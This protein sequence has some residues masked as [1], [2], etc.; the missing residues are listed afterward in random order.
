M[1]KT[2]AH[3]RYKTTDGT[4]VPGVTTILGILNKPALVRWANQLGLRG[5]DWEKQHTIHTIFAERP[6]VSDRLKF[7]GTADWYGRLDDVT[8]LLDFK[9]GKRIYPEMAYQLAA[10]LSL[11]GEARYTASNHQILRVGRDS[12]EGFEVR[13]YPFLR[14]QWLIFKHCL[15]IYHLQ[16]KEA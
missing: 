9:T 13:T 2:A 12:T 6:L 8:T 15:D 11:L 5:I 4:I 7:G 14:T 3:I 16:K 10:Y 1:G